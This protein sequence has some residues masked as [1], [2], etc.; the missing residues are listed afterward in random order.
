MTG[1]IIGELIALTL[2]LAARGEL[3]L[4]LGLF[5]GAAAGEYELA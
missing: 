4:S 3:N 2:L 5:F 1:I